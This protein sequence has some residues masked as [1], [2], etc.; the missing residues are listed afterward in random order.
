MTTSLFQKKGPKFY[1]NDKH[2]IVKIYSFQLVDFETF[3][4]AIY[5]T[6]YEMHYFM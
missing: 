1:R 2:F 5:A 3:I 6:I 4:L